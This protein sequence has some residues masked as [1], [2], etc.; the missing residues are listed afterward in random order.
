M[1]K[2]T[3]AIL[4]K[5]TVCGIFRTQFRI[6]IHV[7]NDDSRIA[8]S[9]IKGT[10][11]RVASLAKTKNGC[12]I[13]DGKISSKIKVWSVNWVNVQQLLWMKNRKTTKV[14]LV[15]FLCTAIQSHCNIL[16]FK[17]DWSIGQSPYIIYHTSTT[18]AIHDKNAFKKITYME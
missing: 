9:C 15:Y 10:F 14:H 11:S 18:I 1:A 17:K 8:I 3:E 16:Y 2:I 4:N 13:F 5:I 6:E 7:L 12:I